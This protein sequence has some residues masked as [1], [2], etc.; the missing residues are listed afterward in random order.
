MDTVAAF[1]FSATAR[2]AHGRQ[3]VERPDFRLPLCTVRLLPHS[4]SHFHKDCREG[5]DPTRY[6]TSQDP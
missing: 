2:S 6:S 3:R 4:H 5:V 1:S